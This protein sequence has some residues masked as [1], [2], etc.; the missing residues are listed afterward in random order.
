[1]LQYNK[2]YIIKAENIHQILED[3][4][5]EWEKRKKLYQMKV[6]KS[7]PSSLVAENDEETKIAFESVISNMVN[8]YM[9]GKAPIYSVDEIPTEEKQNILKKLFNKMIEKNIKCL[10][11]L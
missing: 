11:I 4:K 1:M 9:G 8:G 3:A 5:P 2:E 7:K 10:L 6:R